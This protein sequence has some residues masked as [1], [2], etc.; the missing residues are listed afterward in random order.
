MAMR[1]YAEAE[2]LLQR[3]LKIKEFK[4]GPDHLD[5][6]QSLFWLATLY[7]AMEQ[8]AKAEPLYRAL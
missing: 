4:L 5:V 3:S 6:A 7:T 1:Q 8:Y 2:S